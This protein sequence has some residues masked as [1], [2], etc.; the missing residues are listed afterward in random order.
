MK[1]ERALSKVKEFLKSENTYQICEHFWI[2]L[3]IVR[4]LMDNVCYSKELVTLH[5]RWMDLKN[6]RVQFIGNWVK[7]K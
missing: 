5:K 4:V 2:K 3:C 1:A 6:T 7:I